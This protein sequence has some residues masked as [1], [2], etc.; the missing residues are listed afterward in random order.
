MNHFLR[1]R[2]HPLIIWAL[3]I[4]LASSNPN[5]LF[6]LKET[7]ENI[8]FLNIQLDQFIL[9]FTQVILYMGFTFFIARATIWTKPSNAMSLLAAF[10]L[11]VLFA[12]VN[13]LYQNLIPDRGFN[14][15]DILMAGW[16]A[17]L[18]LI[19]YIIWYHPFDENR[20]KDD[21]LI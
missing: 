8:R 13:G 15:R 18:G 20:H 4:F 11:A 9:M 16:G 1:K 19:T 3:L 2:W 5:P 17:L 14:T 12:L 21:S 10:V 6:G 7:A